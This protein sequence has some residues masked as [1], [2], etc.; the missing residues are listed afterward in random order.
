MDATE[1]IRRIYRSD[2]EISRHFNMT[3]LI[4]NDADYVVVELKNNSTG[5]D[6]ESIIGVVDNLFKML[7][8]A[9]L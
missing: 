7:L 1:S 6:L 9:G 8:E 5:K 2:N 4:I 3:S